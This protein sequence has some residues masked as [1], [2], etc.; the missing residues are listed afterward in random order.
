MSRNI[1][2]RISSFMSLF[3]SAVSA[4]SAVRQHRQP[5]RSDLEALGIDADQFRLIRQD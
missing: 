4:A 5:R 3:G 1:P 2:A